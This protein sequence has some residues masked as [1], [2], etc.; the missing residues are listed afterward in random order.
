MLDTL[1][2]LASEIDSIRLSLNLLWEFNDRKFSAY[3]SAQKSL[4]LASTTLLDYQSL[5]ADEKLARRF[6]CD[7]LGKAREA[8]KS[9]GEAEPAI[10]K[11]EEIMPR[12]ET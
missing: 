8:L 11:I 1:T 2:T 10:H 5:G 9:S 12:L 3:A 7:T 4:D 6:A